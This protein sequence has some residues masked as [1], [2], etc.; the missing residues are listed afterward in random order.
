MLAGS[1]YGGQHSILSNYGG[2]AYSLR[3]GLSLEV[4][5]AFADLDLKHLDWRV[6][7]GL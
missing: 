6:Q 5:L 2:S 4:A 1:I 7:E 3:M